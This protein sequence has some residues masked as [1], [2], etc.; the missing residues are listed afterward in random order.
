MG[1]NEVINQPFSKSKSNIKVDNPIDS[2][3]PFMRD[4]LRDIEAGQAVN[5]K[6]F[7][8]CEESSN[9]KHQINKISEALDQILK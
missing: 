1:F 3:K 8:L 5:V 7:L 6:S 9:K 2:N 4:N